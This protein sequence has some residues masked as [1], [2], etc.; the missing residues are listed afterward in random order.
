MEKKVRVFKTTDEFK[1]YMKEFAID[2]GNPIVGDNYFVMQNDAGVLVALDLEKMTATYYNMDK[3]KSIPLGALI[4][5]AKEF[6]DNLQV[7]IAEQV[8]EFIATRNTKDVIETFPFYFE[9]WYYGL[10]SKITIF[11]SPIYEMPLDKQLITIW[12][13]IKNYTDKEKITNELEFAL[14]QY[15]KG[16]YC[17]RDVA[18]RLQCIYND[19]TLLG[20]IYQNV[21]ELSKKFDFQS[22]GSADVYNDDLEIVS[23]EIMKMLIERFDLKL[24][25]S[26]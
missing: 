4:T 11:S 2:W 17:L 3:P 20:A 22:K 8:C 24:L 6:L 25:K 16:F 13:D 19:N 5:L 12:K 23:I 18:G 7:G 26:I 15:E 14:M 21:A 10:E 9:L 1:A